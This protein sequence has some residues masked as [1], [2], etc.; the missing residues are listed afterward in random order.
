MKSL[1]GWLLIAAIAAFSPIGCVKQEAPIGADVRGQI[2]EAYGIEALGTIQ[3]IQY[4]FHQRGDDRTVRRFWIWEP[5][6]DRVTYK[7]GDYQPA[8]SYRREDLPA[9]ASDTV[10]QIDRWFLHDN[11]WL[12]LPFRVAWDHRAQVA[13]MGLCRTPLAGESARCV[14]VVYP[15]KIKGH[16][17]GDAYKL[18][19]DGNYRILEA[20]YQP[21]D[22]PRKADALRWTQ[23]RYV[24]PLALSLKREDG[25]GRARVWFSGVGVQVEGNK[26]Y[27][28]D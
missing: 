21:E 24:G 19:L 9:T 18:F 8:V 14:N 16:I 26:W 27:W 23:Y 20:V 11:Y 3:K 22:A 12:I 13:D 7:A 10:K 6:S 25:Q 1:I 15:A 5:E 4:T 17:I 28:A 2:A